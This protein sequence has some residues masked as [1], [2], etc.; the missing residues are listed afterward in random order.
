MRV[1][2]CTAGLLVGILAAQPLSAQ[3]K[4]P[5]AEAFRSDAARAGKNLVAALEAMPAD[6]FGYK[7]T[8]AQMSVGQ[9]ANHLAE[10]NDFLCGTIGG[11]KAPKR[12]EVADTAA[13]AELVSLVK[14]TFAFCD[15]AL[16]KLDDSN[17][18]EELPFFG[19]RKSSRATVMVVTVAD[20]ADHYS[21]L[22]I[23]LRFNGLLP[24][25]ANQ[26]EE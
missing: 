4:N 16:A 19:G 9:I 18:A 12:T 1:S 23:Y 17:L 22:A 8:P 2:I 14:E 24:P 26:K 6:K 13:K 10:G 7:P 25:T 3:S 20:W 11:M 15:Q 21:Q 5:V